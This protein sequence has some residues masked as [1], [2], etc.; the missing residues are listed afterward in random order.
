MKACSRRKKFLKAVELLTHSDP[1]SAF[2]N[3]KIMHEKAYR[4]RALMNSHNSDEES[5]E[6]SETS[7][8]QSLGNDS[9]RKNITAQTPS[10]SRASKQAP[11]PHPAAI[12]GSE[13]SASSRRASEPSKGKRAAEQH[14]GTPQ[15]EPA[16]TGQRKANQAASRL[17]Q[18][19]VPATTGQQ[20]KSKVVASAN[21]TEETPT[22]AVDSISS[23]NSGVAAP[24]ATRK[25]RSSSE[26]TA[27]AEK[28]TPPEV[29]KR[30]RAAPRAKVEKKVDTPLAVVTKKEAGNAAT[31]PQFYTVRYIIFNF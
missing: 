27:S 7:G 25:K 5:A 16:R 12:A 23:E 1:L 31:A 29:V 13:Q 22:P 24:R 18:K 26:V 21:D 19:S 2:A 20:R 28:A 11:I 8:S 4:R 14:P 15:S 9:K 3:Y 10:R 30:P 6:E 17:S